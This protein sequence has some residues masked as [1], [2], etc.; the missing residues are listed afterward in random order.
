M[1]LA[2]NEFNFSSLLK[3]ISRYTICY[4]VCFTKFMQIAFLHVAFFDT[5]TAAAA[6][7]IQIRFHNTF[8]HFDW[9]QIIQMH[10]HKCKST[11]SSLLLVCNFTWIRM[12]RS[13]AVAFIF[14][15][16]VLFISNTFEIGSI[17]SFVQSP[18]CSAVAG[19]IPPSPAPPDDI[20]C[21]PSAWWRNEHEKS[22]YTIVQYI[23]RI[24]SYLRMCAHNKRMLKVLLSMKMVLSKPLSEMWG[25]Q[26]VS[27]NNKCSCLFLYW[28]SVRNETTNQQTIA[29]ILQY[30][31]LSVC[32]RVRV[33]GCAIKVISFYFTISQ[34]ADPNSVHTPRY[35]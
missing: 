18:V 31:R 34:E 21:K 29:S 23:I 1:K 8:C 7:L 33:T 20:L 9:I 2:M 26:C 11:T 25:Y 12:F 28:K 3:F 16:F 14:V 30:M 27:R 35:L 6:N 19:A 17:Y 4:L 15:C 10:A 24:V 5:H 13:D 32:E 22:T